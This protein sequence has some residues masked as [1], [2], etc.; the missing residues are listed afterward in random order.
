L[1][2][3]EYILMKAAAGFL[4]NRSYNQLLNAPFVQV[5]NVLIYRNFLLVKNSATNYILLL[6]A[7]VSA[8]K[9]DNFLC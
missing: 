4:E 6:Y 8:S 2:Q 1:L 7:A 3:K 9:S 5:R